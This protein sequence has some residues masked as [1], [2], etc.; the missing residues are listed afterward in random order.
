MTGCDEG[1]QPI[2]RS[3]RRT[4]CDREAV[5]TVEPES[6]AATEKIG[7]AW[8]RKVCGQHL[9]VAVRE[10]TNAGTPV[11]SPYPCR[12]IVTYHRG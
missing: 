9:S 12:V 5:W 7:N 3:G 8:V 4:L 10:A 11:R 6:L 1:V 2:G